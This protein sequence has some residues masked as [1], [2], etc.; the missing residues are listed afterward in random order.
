MYEFITILCIHLYTTLFSAHV[1]MHYLCIGVSI[2]TYMSILD[3]DPYSPLHL[4]LHLPIKSMQMGWEK[5]KVKVTVIVENTGPGLNF[6]FYSI[7]Y[8]YVS[9]LIGFS[10]RRSGA[11][12]FLE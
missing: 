5:C 9:G 1:I 10:K 3:L 8:T 12:V 6:W 2:I 7:C 4:N 11:I